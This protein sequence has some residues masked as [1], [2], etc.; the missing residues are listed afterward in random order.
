MELQSIHILNMPVHLCNMAMAKGYLDQNILI[1]EKQFIIAQNPEKIMKEL[2]D[3][4]LASIVKNK[5]TLLIADGI[6]LVY[7]GKILGLP[8]ICRVTGVGLFEELL[9]VANL[10]EKRVFLYGAKPEVIDKVKKVVESRYPYLILAGTQDGFEE[11]NEL[12][13]QKINEAKP[14]YLFV[15]LGSPAQEKWIATHIDRLSVKLVMGVGGTFDVLTGRIKRAPEFMQKRGLE[16]LYRLFKQPSRI[17]RM[18]NL[19][20]FLIKVIF[21]KKD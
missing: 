18:L 6:G 21:S 20:W 11:D 2:K 9:E 4:E 10:N 3:E 13:I 7:A 14:D 15:A 5:A 12:I 16:W 1:G 17:K 8:H 19:P